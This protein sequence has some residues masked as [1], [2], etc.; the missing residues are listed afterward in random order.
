V[1]TARYGLIIYIYFRLFQSFRVVPW[2]LRLVTDLS[3]RRPGFD[4]KPAHVTFMVHEVA[5][6]QVFRPVHYLFSVSI[7]SPMLHTYF[8]LYF[9]VTR[10]QKERSLWTSKKKCV[11]GYREHKKSISGYREHK[12]CVSGYREHKKSVSGY[13]EHKKSVSGYREHKKSVCAWSLQG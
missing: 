11:S 7:V 1:F 6:G 4:F 13:R 10:K 3:S 8:Y 12:K 9:G 5:L 2:H